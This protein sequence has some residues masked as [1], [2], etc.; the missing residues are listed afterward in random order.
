MSVGFRVL[1]VMLLV[2]LLLAGHH[3]RWPAVERWLEPALSGPRTEEPSYVSPVDHL[4][5]P[6]ARLG[7]VRLARVVV[8]GV[9][10][11]RVPEPPEPVSATLSADG[12][13]F[14]R[15][16]AMDPVEPSPADVETWEI[17]D[18]EPAVE[19]PGDENF[20]PREMEESPRHLEPW[21]DAVV[22]DGG[23]MTELANAGGFSYPPAHEPSM[24]L[25]DPGFEDPALAVPAP[26][27]AQDLEPGLEAVFYE[28]ENVEPQLEAQ[29]AAAP[30]GDEALYTVR[31]GDNLWK[32]ARRFLGA[33]SRLAWLEERN[34][35]L[36]E[37][38]GGKLYVGDQLIVPATGFE[39]SLKIPRGNV[40]IPVEK[41][42]VVNAESQ[43]EAP[44]G[45]RE[46]VAAS[47]AP[48]LHRVEKDETLTRIARKYFPGDPLAWRRVFEANSEALES[49]DFVRAGMLLEIPP[50]HAQDGDPK[51]VR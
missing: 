20:V 18:E 5:D 21:K 23:S 35:E 27:L 36:L 40:D 38:R 12:I 49:P 8:D 44:A 26:A 41:S 48:V 50:A 17:L 33:G 37:K 45:R 1:V 22:A 46:P 47:V 9:G 4:V 32:L 3:T 25:Q 34:S 42:S 43:I 11:T 24:H 39:E 15:G 30:T 14:S 7:L 6:R 31:D 29:Q 16:Y 51:K 19:A 28:E 10:E 13:L 2:F